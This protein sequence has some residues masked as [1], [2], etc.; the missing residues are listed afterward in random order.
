MFSELSI[1]VSLHLVTAEI[2]IYLPNV[3]L[4]A[5]SVKFLDSHESLFYKNPSLIVNFGLRTPQYKLKWV[6]MAHVGVGASS[7]TNFPAHI[8]EIGSCSVHITPSSPPSTTSCPPA[9]PS[10]SP[11]PPTSHPAPCLPPPSWHQVLQDAANPP[12]S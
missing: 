2:S 10:S 7:K 11:S 3:Q 5:S 6:Q 4:W 8:I 1:L 12:I 9:S